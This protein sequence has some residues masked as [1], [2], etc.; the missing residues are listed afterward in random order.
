VDA[1]ESPDL[2]SRFEVKGYP[3]IKYFDKGSPDVPEDYT[4]GRWVVLLFGGGEAE[5]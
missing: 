4:G 5:G 2:G 3:T 1:T